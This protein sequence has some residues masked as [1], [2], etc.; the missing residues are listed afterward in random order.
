[1]T[2]TQINTE[3]FKPYGFNTATKMT[4]VTNPICTNTTTKQFIAYS[5]LIDPAKL[6]AGEYWISLY[7]Y[8]SP[9]CNATFNLIHERATEWTQTYNNNL[10]YCLSEETKGEVFWMWAKLKVNTDGEGYVMFYPNVNQ[11]GVFTTGYMLFTGVEI[12]SASNLLYKP[13]YDNLING[14]YTI[15]NTKNIQNNRLEFNDIIEI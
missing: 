11:A 8:T 5:Y 3:L 15:P 7:G 4:P 12:Y 2:I 10:Y 9:D 14:F 13:S 1:M 6:S